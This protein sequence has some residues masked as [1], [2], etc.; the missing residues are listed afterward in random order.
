MVL[1]I[2][3]VV[4]WFAA[5]GFKRLAPERRSAMGEKGKAP[6]AIGIALGLVL[7]IIGYRQAAFIEIW[8][9]PEFLTH[10]NNLIMVVAVAVFAMAHTKGRMRG[11]MRHP[12]LTSVKMWA[13][14]HLLV[15]GDLASI[16][17][18]GGML[19]WAVWTVIKINRAEEW[20]RPE[21]GEDK[22]DWKFLV[23]TVVTFAVMVGVHLWLGVSPFGARG[24]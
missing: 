5:H 6:I 11:R 17:L 10:I 18:F 3:G 16:I 2:A 8:S 13:A 15:N 7:M 9:P 24:A 14:A 4:L 1:L 22:R 20:Q 21:P 23:V 12:M 19:G